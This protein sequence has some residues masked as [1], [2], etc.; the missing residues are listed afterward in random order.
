MIAEQP[1]QAGQ[2]RRTKQR[3]PEEF[4]ARHEFVLVLN[5]FDAG[6]FIDSFDRHAGPGPAAIGSQRKPGNHSS[7]GHEQGQISQDASHE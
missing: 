6:Y 2:K 5:T 7:N 1:G 3:C 4:Q